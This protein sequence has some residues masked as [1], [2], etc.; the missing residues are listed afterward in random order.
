MRSIPGCESIPAWRVDS[1]A[2]RSKLALWPSD[3]PQLYCMCVQRAALAAGT[4]VWVPCD[5]AYARA[6]VAEAAPARRSPPAC[7]PPP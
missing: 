5:G 3:M 7:E 2:L 6:T 4:E 1:W